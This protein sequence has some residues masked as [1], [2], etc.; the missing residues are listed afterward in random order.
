MAREQFDLIILG[1][2]PG[3]YVAAI[4]AAQLGLK[5]AVVEKDVKL[6][7]TCGLRRCIPTK[8][9]LYTA[10]V[11]DEIKGSAVLAID[12]A[13]PNLDLPSAQDRKQKVLDSHAKGGELLRKK[14]KVMAGTRMA[15]F[16][17]TDSG[18]RLELQKGEKSETLEAEKLLVAVG[19]RPVTENLGLEALGVELERGYVKVNPLMQTAVP[20]IYAIGDV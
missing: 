6:G 14:N 4:R 11:L 13:A 12:V 2:G 9:L 1:S 18:V 5:T 10:A 20:H 7:G 15:G 8:A 17:K 16:A 19:R 3:G